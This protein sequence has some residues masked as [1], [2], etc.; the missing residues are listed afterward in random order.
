MYVCEYLPTK[1]KIKQ[2]NEEEEKQMSYSSR[3][4]RCF[5]VPNT[6]RHAVNA[7]SGLDLRASRL[8][9]KQNNKVLRR[10]LVYLFIG[11]G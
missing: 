8:S 2:K 5:Y 6:I 7:K 3:S 1:K 11:T 9:M 4:S 10:I